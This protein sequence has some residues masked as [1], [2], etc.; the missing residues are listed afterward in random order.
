MGKQ[1]AAKM[2]EFRAVDLATSWIIC[3]RRY[4]DETYGLIEVI[5]KAAMIYSQVG[6]KAE[7]SYKKLQM[8][9]LQEIAEYF[10]MTPHEGFLDV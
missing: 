3:I 10:N 5:E 2:A 6:L 4:F 9:Q 8:V 7:K 1:I